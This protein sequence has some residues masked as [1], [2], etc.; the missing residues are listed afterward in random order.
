MLKI[1]GAV[2]VLLPYPF[3]EDLGEVERT[4]R[5][6]VDAIRSVRDY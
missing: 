2:T 6:A 3:T 4:E 5:T 1:L